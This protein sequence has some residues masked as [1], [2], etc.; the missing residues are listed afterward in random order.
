MTFLIFMN[1]LPVTVTEVPPTIGPEPTD[2]VVTT[3]CA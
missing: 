1:P 3:G 2:R